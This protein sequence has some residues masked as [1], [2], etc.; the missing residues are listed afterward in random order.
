MNIFTLRSLTWQDIREIATEV[1][2][3][4]TIPETAVE[5]PTEEA[6]YEAAKRRIADNNKECIYG[7]TEEERKQNCRFCS[8][9]CKRGRNY[10]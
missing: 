2:L 5:Y 4:K 6:F 8:R 7:Y 10:E 1:A 9:W 3:M